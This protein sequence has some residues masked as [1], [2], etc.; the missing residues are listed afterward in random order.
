MESVTKYA[1]ASLFFLRS[2]SPS[3]GKTHTMYSFPTQRHPASDGSLEAAG[4]LHS[5]K[6]KRN[7]TS[8]SKA[9]ATANERN[10]ILKSVS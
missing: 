5:K 6:K 9:F 1:E 2:E 8:C 10:L 4:D 7:T 3:G